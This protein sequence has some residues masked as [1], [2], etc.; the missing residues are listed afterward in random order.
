MEKYQP[1]AMPLSGPSSR[2]TGHTFIAH[3]GPLQGHN[4]QDASSGS[5]AI[6]LDGHKGQARHCGLFSVLA[7]KIERLTEL[8]EAATA[9][10]GLLGQW[11]MKQVDRLIAHTPTTAQMQYAEAMIGCEPLDAYDDLK[12]VIRDCAAAEAVTLQQGPRKAAE[13]LSQL[14][15]EILSRSLDFRK[16]WSAVSQSND[17][18]LNPS[19]LVVVMDVLGCAQMTHQSQ[20][21][22]A[23]LFCGGSQAE[24]RPTLQVMKDL[25]QWV[26]QADAYP[27]A[28]TAKDSNQKVGTKRKGLAPAK[29]STQAHT[30]HAAQAG[31]RRSPLKR[32][33][34]NMTV[35]ASPSSS[36]IQRPGLPDSLALHGPWSGNVD[37]RTQMLQLMKQRVLQLQ[38]AMCFSQQQLSQHL[39]LSRSQ[40]VSSS[41]QRNGLAAAAKVSLSGRQPLISQQQGHA[42]PL[43]EPLSGKI[44]AMTNSQVQARAVHPQPIASAPASPPGEHAGTNPPAHG[45]QGAASAAT[46]PGATSAYVAQEAVA[47]SA[48]RAGGALTDVAQASSEP[49]QQDASPRNG[50]SPMAQAPEHA[51]VRGSPREYQ[52]LIMDHCFEIRVLAAHGLLNHWPNA[53]AKP[54]ARHLIYSFPGADTQLMSPAVAVG[55]NARFNASARHILSLPAS[56][57]LAKALRHVPDAWDLSFQVWDEWPGKEASLCAE[58]RL[59]LAQL[60]QLVPAAEYSHEYFAT[61]PGAPAGQP[62]QPLLRTADPARV[63]YDDNT[64]SPEDGRQS[65]A[66][67][68]GSCHAKTCRQPR[69]AAFGVRAGGIKTAGAYRSPAAAATGTAG[70]VSEQPQLVQQSTTDLQR[71]SQQQLHSEKVIDGQQGGERRQVDVDH[72]VQA[73]KANTASILLSLKW[74]ASSRV[75]PAQEQSSLGSGP[76]LRVKVSY[77]CHPSRPSAGSPLHHPQQPPADSG[78]DAQGVVGADEVADIELKLQYVTQDVWLVVRLKQA[79]GLAAAAEEAAS[80]STADKRS[81]A[82]IGRNGPRAIATVKL[83]LQQPVQISTAV[84]KASFCPQWGHQ[85][86]L[87]VP[88]NREAAQMIWSK[89]MQLDVFHQCTKAQAIA[90]ALS[91]G[92][93][94]G[95]K[96]HEAYQQTLLGSAS[97]AMQPLLTHPRGV[98]GWQCLIS[99]SGKPAGAIQIEAF[100]STDSAAEGHITTPRLR[101]LLDAIPALQTWLPA[102]SRPFAVQQ[103]LLRGQAVCVQLRLHHACLPL[104]D[105]AHELCVSMA[106]RLPTDESWL[107]SEALMCMPC[108]TAFPHPGQLPKFKV[109]GGVDILVTGNAGFAAVLAVEPMEVCIFNETGFKAL[110]GATA[111]TDLIGTASVDLWPLIRGDHTISKNF[112]L[113]AA[114]AKNLQGAAITLEVSL[115]LMPKVV[116]E[117][118][119]RCFGGDVDEE[120]SLLDSPAFNELLNP[121]SSAPKIRPEAQGLDQPLPSSAPPGSKSTLPGSPS[122]SPEQPEQPSSDRSQGNEYAT[123]VRDSQ[124]EDLDALAHHIHQLTLTP[125]KPAADQILPETSF[126]AGSDDEGPDAGQER[127][128]DTSSLTS[129]DSDAFL[130]GLMSRI[131]AQV[132]PDD[133]SPR[134]P[135]ME[136]AE[137]SSQQPPG[138]CQPSTIFDEDWLF[139]ISRHPSAQPE[140]DETFEDAPEHSHSGLATEAEARFTA[141]DCTSAAETPTS[142]QRFWFSNMLPPSSAFASNAQLP[143]VSESPAT[144]HIHL[145]G[146]E[147]Q[148]AMLLSGAC[149]AQ[150]TSNGAVQCTSAATKDELQAAQTPPKL[151]SQGGL[152]L[153]EP[154]SGLFVTNPQLKAAKQELTL[155]HVMP[156]P[157]GHSENT[158]PNLQP[159]HPDW[160]FSCRKPQRSN[161]STANAQGAK[162]LP[163]S[164]LELWPDAVAASGRNS[165]ISRTSKDAAMEMVSVQPISHQPNLTSPAR[166][167]AKDYS[168][169]INPAASSGQPTALLQGCCV[170]SISQGLDT[171]AYELQDQ[172]FG[173]SAQEAT[174][175]QDQV[176]SCQGD[177]V[178]GAHEDHEP[179]RGTLVQEAAPP[180]DPHLSSQPEDSHVTALGPHVHSAQAFGQ[181]AALL[182]D[183]DVSSCPENSGVAARGHHEQP[184]R[185]ADWTAAFPQGPDVRS[186][187]QG[188][189][190]TRLHGSSPCTA[191]VPQQQPALQ[192]ASEESTS[193]TTLSAES[194]A[195]PSSAVFD[196]PAASPYP[197]VSSNVSGLPY[198]A[199]GTAGGL[200][201][202]QQ[203]S[204]ARLQD[205]IWPAGSR[206]PAG[207]STACPAS[208]M[209]DILQPPSVGSLLEGMPDFLSGNPAWNAYRSFN[210]PMIDP[211]DFS[212]AGLLPALSSAS[213]LLECPPGLHA[214]AGTSELSFCIPGARTRLHDP[215]N[216]LSSQRHGWSAAC[217]SGSGHER[218]LASQDLDPGLCGTDMPSPAATH[219]APSAIAESA[220]LR[221]PHAHGMPADSD[222]QQPLSTMQPCLLRG[223]ARSSSARVQ[224]SA[225][226]ALIDATIKALA[227]RA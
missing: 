68:D 161:S 138:Q 194:P 126:L 47:A 115:D 87:L 100:L 227:D 165:D 204:S 145:S 62:H 118:Q 90:A 58:G 99:P 222:A 172:T 71:L 16:A 122:R 139:D 164:P 93:T 27:E 76:M 15:H 26:Q 88:L 136:E 147:K 200:D 124:L 53:E 184:A 55:A 205:S 170:S 175:P 197:A 108:P 180:Q 174:S 44:L 37:T 181:P 146:S 149:S 153:V 79:I 94:G 18:G 143:S 97:M 104:A 173:A 216:G 61:G 7:S 154:I 12:Q 41:S 142:S 178:V 73:S 64:H 2:P 191:T 198:H 66:A 29:R 95:S 5:S 215:C 109:N 30:R 20:R 102:L 224:P 78:K 130:E 22:L 89:D 9:D 46:S 14:A 116:S 150:H 166:H 206:E 217:A 80:W 185:A 42:Q 148:E 24:Q 39:E 221:A 158:P 10:K 132:P 225:A 21:L 82:P 190:M 72:V 183:P 92:S 59:P 199:C 210:G 51:E 152:T 193:P 214:P 208:M 119:I 111:E 207:S 96:A 160:L 67:R 49:P 28:G 70:M 188:P 75:Q 141:A 223:E 151:A 135:G 91:A 187:L 32:Q 65:L 83:P 202:L 218:S 144:C 133:D 23:L 77:S 103:Q 220:H 211:A 60:M 85:E 86:T 169:D 110:G 121:A 36:V 192:R 54:C 43:E 74:L 38:E 128:W 219:T 157:D 34:S 114:E 6:V 209:E 131:E 137:F 134:Y 8:P 84:H 195:E 33:R 162:Q 81:S 107:Q 177:S 120:G 182:Q 123:S 167:E 50:S 159:L 129:N 35:V 186:S 212:K 213:G 13:S 171:A 196:H 112:M 52:E 203:P 163:A 127:S 226:A 117:E 105:C 4:K 140:E 98:S 113:I 45:A 69:Q 179:V 57:G 63:V 11:L 176:S 40:T 168:Q 101:P 156:A 19:Q 155:Q 189:D 48:M 106:A 201:I 56:V 125:H 3:G 31:P 1:D 17:I 25:M